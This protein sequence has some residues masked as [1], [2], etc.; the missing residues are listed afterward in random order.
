MDATR[1][2]ITLE[3]GVNF[4]IN[5][6]KIMEGGEIFIPKLP[7][8]KIIDLAKAI[9]E[10]REIKMIGLRESEKIHESLISPDEDKNVLDFKNY[11]VIKPFLF[12]FS[13]TFKNQKGKIAKSNYYF[14]S[15]NSDFL[16]IKE[17]KSYIKKL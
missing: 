9:D 5:S 12:N 16:T 10:K 3:E 14:S 8:I 15:N 11:F 13:K 7:A 1:F 4:V 17:I 6:L 2:W